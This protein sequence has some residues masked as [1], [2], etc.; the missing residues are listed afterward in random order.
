MWLGGIMILNEEFHAL[1]EGTE[2]NLPSLSGSYDRNN[3]KHKFTSIP[4]YGV[5]GIHKLTSA[6]YEE[7]HTMYGPFMHPMLT[8]L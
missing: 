4:S 2:K 5:T 8:R 6:P 7:T 3:N 1:A